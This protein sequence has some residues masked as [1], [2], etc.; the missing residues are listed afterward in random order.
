MR[1]SKD[2][3]RPREYFMDCGKAFVETGWNFRV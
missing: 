2:D 1:K 3:K